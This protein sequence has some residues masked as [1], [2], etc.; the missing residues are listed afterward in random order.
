MQ[1]KIKIN[2]LLPVMAGFFV[3]GF[4]DVVG[5]ASNYI[6]QDFQL[7]DTL[8][9]LILMM[10]YVWFV[11]LSIPTGVLMGRIGRRKTVLISI[12]ATAIALFVPVVSYSFVTVLLA[13]ALLGI[14]N[15]MLQVSLNPLVGDIVPDSKLAS[16]LT[17]GQFVKS[18]ASFSGPVLAGR[19]ALY[20]GNWRYLFPLFGG[21]SV[22]T[23]I[24]LNAVN[25]AESESIRQ[26]G[27]FRDSFILLGDKV[28]L[29]FFVGILLVVGIDVGMNVTVPKYLTLKA[30]IPLEE[31]GLG[32]SVYF[33]AKTAGAFL[34]GFLLSRIETVK[35][36]RV[37]A[38]LSLASLAFTLLVPSLFGVYVGIFLVGLT[39][40]NIF[41]VIFS[42]ALIRK[43]EFSNEI[44]GLMMMGVIGGAIITLVIGIVSDNFGLIAGM[45]VLG[46][47]MVY[48]LGNSLVAKPK[49]ER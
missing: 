11:L 40:A 37:I 20:L 3:M 25:I 6:K 46:V 15:T 38:L 44:S 36:Y 17:F 16:N 26:K 27:S 12:V 1:E 48:L 5:I 19:A 10:L 4:V 33:A 23:A 42:L 39:V 30:D 8:A 47:C 18:I 24:W 2:H 29:G 41:S 35:F 49:S 31:A 7:N 9:N 32:I 45:L 43:P 21:I 34:G 28:I 22:L 14:G 13:L